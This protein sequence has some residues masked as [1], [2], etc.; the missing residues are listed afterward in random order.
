M[1]SMHL[2]KGCHFCVAS[3][4]T[5]DDA[6]DLFQYD[7]ET[8]NSTLKNQCLAQICIPFLYLVENLSKNYGGWD[9]WV[10]KNIRW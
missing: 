6:E 2:V 10:N 7:C 3:T 5:N 4:S 1:F 8:A 9:V